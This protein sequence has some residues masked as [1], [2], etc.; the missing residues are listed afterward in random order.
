MADETP[1]ASGEDLVRAQQELLG[2]AEHGD[3]LAFAAIVPR[4]GSLEEAQR[5]VRER[6]FVRMAERGVVP[7]L[8]LA[9]REATRDDTGDA[10]ATETP[11]LFGHF[12]VF[13]EWTEIDSMFE[14][15]FLERIAPG[16]FKK[17]FAEGRD[18]I[19]V[20]FQHGQDPFLG[21]KVLGKI[22]ALEEDAI[23]AR[24]EVPLFRGLPELLMEGLRA[25]EYGAS[26]RFR[27]MR[28][29]FDEEPDVSD[30]N[31]RGLAERTLKEVQVPEFGPVTYPAYASATAGVRS[32]EESV[33]GNGATEDVAVA[34]PDPDAA[35]TGRTSGNER[36]E[37]ANRFRTR[38][39]WQ[40]WLTSQ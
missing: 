26:F 38:E 36:R 21:D 10:G 7:R 14:G 19:K 15:H 34:P 2:A 12:A 22:D 20:T 33:N 1:R 27:M 24:Y 30:H 3:R 23:G 25:D 8:T 11:T 29:L 40:E 35:A 32:T 5:F 6:A 28:E 13:N 9:I 37:V 16:A 31:P 18:T 4:L 17:T 39:E